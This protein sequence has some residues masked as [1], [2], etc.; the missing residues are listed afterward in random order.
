MGPIGRGEHLKD[1]PTIREIYSNRL[2]GVSHDGA[3][4]SI[5]LAKRRE[6]PLRIG[7]DSSEDSATVNNRVCISEAIAMELY[8]VLGQVLERIIRQRQQP[9]QIPK[10]AVNKS[11]RAN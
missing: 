11:T 4:I 10:P 2:V 9:D 5:L 1:D 3:V 6:L 8:G 7:D